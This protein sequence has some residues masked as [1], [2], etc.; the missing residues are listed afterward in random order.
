MA[1]ATQ[2]RKLTYDDFVEF[3]EDGMRHEIL[4]GEHYM[5]PSPAAKHQLVS[6]NLQY[7]LSRQVRATRAGRVFTA[8]FDVLL[9]T[10]DIV[11]PDLIFISAARMAILTEKNIQGAPD[12]LI[13][14]LSPGT[15]KRDEGLKRQRYEKLGVEEYWLVE[16][17][18]EWVRVYRRAGGGYAHAAERKPGA[19]LTTPLLPGLEIPL[20]EIFA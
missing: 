20:A 14:I 9:S 16:P 2:V 17:D 7:L 13:E 5:S 18:E 10:H 11:E 15:R 6:S 3:P 1:P 8:P 4:D 19:V 12:L